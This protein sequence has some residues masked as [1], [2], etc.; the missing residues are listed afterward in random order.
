MADRSSISSLVRQAYEAVSW[1]HPILPVATP[2]AKYPPY[3]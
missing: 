3:M 2:Q 1:G